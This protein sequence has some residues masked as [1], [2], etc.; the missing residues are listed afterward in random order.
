MK[1]RPILLLLLLVG[2]AAMFGWM[3]YAV[4]KPAL[5]PHKQR[6]DEALEELDRCGHRKH[7]KAVQYEQFARIA[8]EEHRHTVAALFRAMAHSERVQEQYCA[9]AIGKLGGSYTPPQRI[10]LFRGATEGNIDRS[11]RLETAAADSLHQAQIRRHLTRGHRLAARALIWAAANDVRHRH[12]LESHR[13]DEQPSTHHFAVCPE[14]GHTYA[15]DA[16]D[17]FC[18][19]CLTDGKRFVHF[20]EE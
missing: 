5:R 2:A 9:V 10:I 3:Y 8:D 17:S 4:T 19:H 11:I 14:C 15:S 6:S 1:V 18:P 7:V 12:L 16:L 13:R 20:G